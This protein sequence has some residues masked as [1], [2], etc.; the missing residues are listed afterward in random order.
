MYTLF[1]KGSHVLFTNSIACSTKSK[2]VYPI[3][4]QRHIITGIHCNNMQ[5]MFVLDNQLFL[6]ILSDQSS[7][8]DLIK[9]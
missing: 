5:S 9:H 1:R 2:I 3:T 6:L 4:Q 7:S 8:A